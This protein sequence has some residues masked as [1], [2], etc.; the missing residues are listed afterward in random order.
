MRTNFI[1]L[2]NFLK[3]EYQK[4][5]QNHKPYSKNQSLDKSNFRPNFLKLWKLE[6]YLENKIYKFNRM[7]LISGYTCFNVNL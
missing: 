2:R 1:G 3:S 7:L 6:A 5:I 4:R